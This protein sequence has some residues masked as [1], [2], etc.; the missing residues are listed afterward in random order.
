MVKS[1]K[2]RAFLMKDRVFDQSVVGIFPHKEDDLL[3]FLAL[4]NSEVM[5]ELIHIINPT[6][7]NSSNY[8][9]QLPYIEP[10]GNTKEEISALV[11]Q[12]IELQKAGD[13]TTAYALQTEVNDMIDFIYQF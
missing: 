5:N 2:I 7:N 9:K 4:M 13:N 6:A 12:I 10:E 1:S 8:V 3:Y 11:R